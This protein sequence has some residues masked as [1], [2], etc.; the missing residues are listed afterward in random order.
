MKDALL[1][2]VPVAAGQQWLHIVLA[3]FGNES[4]LVSAD[5]CRVMLMVRYAYQTEGPK[6]A[7]VYRCCLAFTAYLHR[8]IG[9]RVL[10]IT[11]NTVVLLWM[12]AAATM[13]FSLPTGAAVDFKVT[14]GMVCKIIR[15]WSL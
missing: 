12:F 15:H 5:W 4:L 7:F 2:S 14:R 10:I 1:A 8:L 11:A 13:Q 9:L 3:S 6:H